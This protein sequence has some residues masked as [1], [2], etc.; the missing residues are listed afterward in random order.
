MPALSLSR[1]R[2]PSLRPRH[3]ILLTND[4]GIGVEGIDVVAQ[5]LL[6]LDGVEVSIV[7]PAENQ[8]GRSD[9]VTDPAPNEA[10]SATTA[11]GLSDFAISGTL[12][13]AVNFALDSVFADDQPALVVSGSNKRQNGGPVT[14]AF[15]TVGAARTAARRGVHAIAIS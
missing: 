1:V 8:S 11:S 15:R 3:H 5:A 14:V 4:H 7:A 2:R 10:E 13:D 12:A 6:G 9:S